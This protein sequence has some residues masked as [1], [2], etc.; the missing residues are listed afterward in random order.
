[1]H[2]TCMCTLSSQRPNQRQSHSQREHTTLNSLFLKLLFLKLLNLK[3]L[4]LKLLYGQQTFSKYVYYFY[5]FCC[6]LLFAF[7]FQT[8]WIKGGL[9]YNITIFYFHVFFFIRFLVIL[10]KCS[11]IELQLVG[12]R[13][14]TRCPNQFYISPKYRMRQY[15]QLVFIYVSNKRCVTLKM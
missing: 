15:I 4:F 9:Y 6:F 13:A 12:Y 7:C 5:S 10:S 1:M 14:P 11:D 3:L 8:I 2:T